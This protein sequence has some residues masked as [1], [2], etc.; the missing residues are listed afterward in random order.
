MTVAPPLEGFTLYNRPPSEDPEV[1]YNVPGV[2]F[3]II[4]PLPVIFTINL[5]LFVSLLVIT[6]ESVNEPPNCGMNAIFA[7][8]LFRL[9]IFGVNTY[10]LTS[11]KCWPSVDTL[12]MA[13]ESVPSFVNVTDNV[14]PGLTT[15]TFF[16]PKG[17]KL[18]SALNIAPA[19][20]PIVTLLVQVPHVFRAATCSVWNQT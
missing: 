2:A 20:G 6:S 15:P 3:T 19:T 9:P 1:A 17:N 7:V 5:G 12:E 11:L 10:E 8:M 18:R 16:T 13:I 14:S 4:N